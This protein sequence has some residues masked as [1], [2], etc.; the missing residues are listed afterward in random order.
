MIRCEK[1]GKTFNWLAVDEFDRD[2]SDYDRC[3]FVDTD[4][5]TED[6]EDS[7]YDAV[8]LDTNANWT[9]YGMS[10]EEQLETIKCPHCGRF[11]FRC[12]EIQVYDIVR[13]VMFKEKSGT[14]V[15][16]KHD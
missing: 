3:Y 14:A 15:E 5:G 2:G 7:E 9:G 6:K 8:W 16:V 13:I 1:C 11:P 12:K 4:E 10:E